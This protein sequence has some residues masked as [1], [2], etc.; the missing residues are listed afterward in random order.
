MWVANITLPCGRTAGTPAERTDTVAA[1]TLTDWH[2]YLKRASSYRNPSARVIEESDIVTLLR[3][4]KEQ[5]KE[6]SLLQGKL[7]AI[8]S[9]EVML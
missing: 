7:L 8:L 4:V 1:L 5:L 9:C 2:N 3:M 6:L